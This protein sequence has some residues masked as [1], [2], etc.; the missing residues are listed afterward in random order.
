[1]AQ[2]NQAGVGLVTAYFGAD[3]FDGSGF[4]LT[5]SGYF[6]TNRHVVT[7]DGQS[8]DS[9]FITMADQR[10]MI[11]SDMVALG[12]ATGPDL[13]MLKIRNYAGPH[14][15]RVDWTGERARQGE[16]AALI[17]FPAGLAAALDRSQ[18][19]RTSMSAGVFSKVTPELIQFDGFTVGG[20]SGSPIFNAD[21]EVVAVHR[22]GLRE[23][24]GLGF[25]VPIP[26]L[27]S[28]LP[29]DARAELGLQQQQ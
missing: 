27:I 7:E 4:V 22:A 10:F 2:A 11:R 21:G 5:A 14:I 18:T 12:P 19:V 9:L 26:L 28:L 29:P 3:L 6:V 16:P 13:A 20:S 15:D 8:A 17:G 23:A 24:A 25:A 1:V